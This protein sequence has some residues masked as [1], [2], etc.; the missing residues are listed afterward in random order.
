MKAL[1]S[2]ES[3]GNYFPNSAASHP[4]R[5]DLPERV[6][7]GQKVTQ[8]KYSILTEE[9]LDELHARF[10]ILLENPSD[11]LHRRLGLK[12]VTR[13]C[14]D[15]THEVEA[16]SENG[17]HLPRNAEARYTIGVQKYTAAL[18]K[19]QCYVYRHGLLWPLLFRIY[20]ACLCRLSGRTIFGYLEGS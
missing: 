20:V 5:L 18:L 19:I 15:K 13:S 1:R 11:T 14:R 2:F 3:S 7:I 6:V 8:L 16:V 12:T 10:N 17:G 9:K 4:R